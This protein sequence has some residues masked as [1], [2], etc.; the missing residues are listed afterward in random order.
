[1]LGKVEVFL[2]NNVLQYYSISL[3]YTYRAIDSIT[4]IPRALSF[5][6]KGYRLEN[7]S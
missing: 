3:C 7:L 2:M 4:H 5:V 6:G 1:M